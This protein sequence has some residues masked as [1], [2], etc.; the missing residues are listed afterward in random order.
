MTRD[1]LP[2]DG[3]AMVTELR[4]EYA[5]VRRALTQRLKETQATAALS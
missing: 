2:T 3:V 5:R 1:T 4:E